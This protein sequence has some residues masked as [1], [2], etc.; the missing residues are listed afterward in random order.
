MEQRRLGREGLTVSA[1]GLGCMGMSEFYGEADEA[2][3]LAT[4][5]RAVELGVTF[6]DTADMYGSGHNEE[7]VGRF[8]RESGAPVAIAT[9]FGI[10]RQPGT[11]ERTIDNSPAYVAEA[12]EASLRRLGIETIDLYYAHRV[13]KDRPIEETVG[14][15]AELVKAGKVRHLGLSEVSAATLR[16]AH[17]VHPIAAVQTEYSLWTR[18][19]EDSVLPCCRELGIGF[20]PYSPLGRGFLTGT[21][22]SLDGLADNDFRRLSPRFQDGAIDRNLALVAVVEAIAAEAGATPAQVALAWVLARGDDIVPIPGTKRRRYLE[23]NLAALDV[24]LSP[25]QTAR[26]DAAF[27]PDQVAGERYPEAGMKGI[28]A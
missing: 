14:A 28:D 12:C 24:T 3:S 7:L 23:D 11:Y 17:A 4:L 6:L 10:R 18:D 5:A 2:E 1:I 21:M 15:M 8:V 16:R 13:E 26:L 20:V 19:V 9:K 27:S 25:E 22:R